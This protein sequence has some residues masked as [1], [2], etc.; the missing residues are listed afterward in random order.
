MSLENPFET[1][2]SKISSNVITYMNSMETGRS[3]RHGLQ[4]EMKEIHAK[5]NYSNVG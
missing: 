4:T 5:K 2:C 3:L 1:R